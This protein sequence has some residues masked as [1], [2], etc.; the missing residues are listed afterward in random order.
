MIYEDIKKN[1]MIK[2]NEIIIG[3]NVSFGRNI[4]IQ[5]H[6]EFSIGSNSRLGNNTLIEGNNITIGEHF[7]NSGGLVIG[8]G[9][10]QYPNANLKIGDR[11]VIHDNI[12]NVCEP[13][14]I[15]NDVGFSGR[16]E[17][18]THGFWLSVLEG[19]PASFSG[20]KIGNGVIL[21]F[22]STILMGVQV[23]DNI[24]LG[25]GSLVTKDLSKSYSVYAGSPARFIRNIVP[26]SIDDR[27]N[28]LEEI[29]EKYK[30][31]AKYHRINPTIK[32]DY[33][34]LKI[35]DFN[36][37]VETFEYDGIEDDET[38]NFRDYFR[39]WGIRIYTTRPFNTHFE[40]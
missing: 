13:V 36:I 14:E 1:L 17:I 21:G 5:V 7:F 40:L 27:I 31:I 22:N 28:K 24:V 18:I 3:K 38:D 19:F 20:I 15:G 32:L 39:K 25:A 12:I 11:C 6:G 29:I 33:P 10:Q 30:D 34:N 9:G 23:A 4:R 37:N 26:L 16:V 8:A 35:N 2:A